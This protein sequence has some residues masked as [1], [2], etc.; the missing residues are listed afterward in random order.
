[1]AEFG[2]QVIKTR[3]F[4]LCNLPPADDGAVQNSQI[5]ESLR[6]MRKDLV[7]RSTLEMALTSL[8]NGHHEHGER[9]EK[10][11]AAAVSLSV[12]EAGGSPVSALWPFSCGLESFAFR[13]VT[14]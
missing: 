6:R 3:E 14:R 10:R 1:M 7:S 2:R 5:L 9:R 11:R 4:E 8:R 13:L 12:A